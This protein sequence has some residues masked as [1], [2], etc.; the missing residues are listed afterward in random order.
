MKDGN[1]EQQR[2]SQ[3]GSSFYSQIPPT[4]GGYNNKAQ[5]EDTGGAT[6]FLGIVLGYQLQCGGRRRCPL[7]L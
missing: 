1:W 2:G 5:E 3:L 4:V 7:Y 6:R